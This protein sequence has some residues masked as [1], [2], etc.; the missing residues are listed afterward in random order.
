MILVSGNGTLAKELLKLSTDD[1]PIT[2]LS[3]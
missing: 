1:L 3:K 2:I